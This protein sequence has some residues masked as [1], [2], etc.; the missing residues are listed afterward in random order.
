[1][2]QQ[3][4]G[5]QHP[6]EQ[7]NQSSDKPRRGLLYY[8]LGLFIVLIVVVSGLCWYQQ[9]V[10][11]Q[12]F[13]QFIAQQRLQHQQL[14][15]LKKQL[16]ELRTQQLAPAVQRYWLL[17]RVRDL[18]Q[19]AH[20]RLLYRREIKLAAHDL[21]RAG[22][23]LSTYKGGKLTLRK[24]V[25]ESLAEVNSIRV[26][27]RGQILL[28]L[29]QL[30]DQFIAAVQQVNMPLQ[31]L[32]DKTVS[33]ADASESARLST[34]EKQH[35]W[36]RW[37]VMVQ[38]YW[39]NWAHQLSKALVVTKVP[40]MQDVVT[41]YPHYWQV[42]GRLYFEQAIWAVLHQKPLLYQRSIKELV[43][44][45]TATKAYYPKLQALMPQVSALQK[46]T[47]SQKL[48]DLAPLLQLIDQQLQSAIPSLMQ[49]QPVE[50]D[51]HTPKPSPT[52]QTLPNKQ[53]KSK[54]KPQSPPK[55]PRND[56][57]SLQEQPSGQAKVLRERLT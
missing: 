21:T 13:E 27:D 7:Q 2:S 30:Q 38:H 43:E 42:H 51:Q 44:K 54:T 9:R 16:A 50:G 15:T 34:V 29:N 8:L 5:Q 52:D 48:P 41:M 57:P 46:I 53:N 1:M 49:Q 6:V 24:A 17:L 14:V 4:Q 47:L 22:Q 56:Q 25:A 31:P 11:Q 28:Q 32:L 45:I 3:E 23:L 10:K 12:R 36:R 18:V 40:E 35:G 26:V 55:K 19:Q 37:L 39:Q 20:D 33:S